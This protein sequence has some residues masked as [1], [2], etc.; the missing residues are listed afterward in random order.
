MEADKVFVRWG[1]WIDLKKQV[2]LVSDGR[3]CSYK[4][5]FDPRKRLEAG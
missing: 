2:R 5:R 4:D 3:S 1:I